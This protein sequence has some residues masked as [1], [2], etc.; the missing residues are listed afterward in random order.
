[1][2]YLFVCLFVCLFIYLFIKG[3][4]AENILFEIVMWL[5]Q[6]SFRFTLS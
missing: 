2:Y 5:I 1:M 4:P 3:L 6:F